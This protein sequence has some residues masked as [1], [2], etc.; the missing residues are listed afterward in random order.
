M[1]TIREDFRFRRVCSQ[2]S[3]IHSS[4]DPWVVFQKVLEVYFCKVS[5]R[6]GAKNNHKQETKVGKR[7]RA[8]HKEVK[9][10]CLQI[11]FFYS[12]WSNFNDYIS[13]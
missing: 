7:Q 8:I 13:P 4:F 5:S 2:N 12:N 10:E 1:N 6:T 3:Q 9:P 11:Y